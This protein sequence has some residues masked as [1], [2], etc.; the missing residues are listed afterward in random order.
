MKTIT[1]RDLERIQTTARTEADTIP[2][3]HCRI[4]EETYHRAIIDGCNGAKERKPG[5]ATYMVVNVGYN[6]GN[7]RYPHWIRTAEIVP[8]S[9]TARETEKS[10]NGYRKSSILA[11][12]K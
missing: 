4:K 8:I 2:K 7:S 1:K 6:Q 9:R 12:V 5:R 11:L 3:R 10:F